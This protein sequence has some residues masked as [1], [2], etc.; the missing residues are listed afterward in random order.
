[1]DPSR[2]QSSKLL[3]SLALPRGLRRPCEFKHLAKS[4]TPNRST[5][6]LG[7]LPPVSHLDAPFNCSPPRMLRARPGG[8]VTGLSSAIVFVTITDPVGSGFVAS[9]QNGRTPLATSR[10]APRRALSG[11]AAMC[12]AM[13]RCGVR[14]T[15][16]ANAGRAAK[17]TDDLASPYP[18]NHVVGARVRRIAAS[19]STVHPT[20]P[21]KL[22]EVPGQLVDIVGQVIGHTDD[23]NPRRGLLH[24]P[25]RGIPERHDRIDLTRREVIREMRAFARCAWRGRW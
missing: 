1:L 25:D 15:G 13:R 5:Q 20:A 12:R 22:L 4:G 21:N 3:K 9:N 16:K 17:Q 18:I 2:R 11:Q 19:R 14:T 23:R 10:W 24:S 7:F 6:S 8:N